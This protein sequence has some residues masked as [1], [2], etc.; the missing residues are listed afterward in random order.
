MIALKVHTEPRLIEDKRLPY[1]TEL[2]PMTHVAVSNMGKIH[3]CFIS[4]TTDDDH[5]KWK[6]MKNCSPYGCD[7]SIKG[8]KMKTPKKLKKLIKK[9]RYYTGHGGPDNPTSPEVILNCHATIRPMNPSQSDNSA[10]SSVGIKL[11]GQY[12]QEVVIYLGGDGYLRIVG[13]ISYSAYSIEE[14]L[15]QITADWQAE[16]ATKLAQTRAG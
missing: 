16:R 2:N 15:L 4:R 8:N 9:L 7:N 14:A 6:D 13:P 1:G 10:K 3:S 12:N 11:V 5:D